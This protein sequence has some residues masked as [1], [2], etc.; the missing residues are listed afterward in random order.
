MFAT[1]FGIAAASVRLVRAIALQVVVGVERQLVRRAVALA[2]LDQPA[3]AAVV[4][5]ERLIAHAVE[6]FAD[7][8]KAGGRTDRLEGPPPS[9]H[10]DRTEDAGE[11]RLRHAR[12]LT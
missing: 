2:Q 11:R 7:E 6:G 8:Q 5:F 3:R 12:F 4:V 10:R 9:G 1:V